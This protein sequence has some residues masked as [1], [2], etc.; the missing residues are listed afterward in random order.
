[1]GQNIDPMDEKDTYALTPWFTPIKEYGVRDGLNIPV[2]GHVGWRLLEG[3]LIYGDFAI[4]KAEYNR[5][6]DA[7]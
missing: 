4:D 6:G 2:F 3:D 5:P 1:M 7:V